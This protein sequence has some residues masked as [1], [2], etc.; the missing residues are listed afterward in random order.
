M[1]ATPFVSVV[2][3][4]IR[5]TLLA[6]VLPVILSQ[7]YPKGE[8]EVIVVED[9]TESKV[10]ELVESLSSSS[11][12]EIS[13]YWKERGGPAAAR[14]FGVSKAKGDFIVFI[15]DDCLPSVDWLKILI[16][17]FSS[18]SQA[19]AVGGYME[20]PE[21]LLVKNIFAQF[22]SYQTHQVYKAGSFPILSGFDSPAGGSNNLAYKKDIF[23]DF[24]GFDESFPLPAGE[25]ADLKKRITDAG[26]KFLYLPVKVTHLQQYNFRRFIY[27]SIA[28]GKGAMLFEK[29][30]GGWRGNWG[31][32]LNFAY[33]WL[34]FIRNLLKI[35]NKKI[36]ILYLI[37]DTLM[38]WGR[39]L[40]R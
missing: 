30:H 2:I 28:R 31:L 18:Y 36:V 39:T 22:E 8:Y 24:G 21:D 10:K 16:Q 27:Q 1:S 17:G 5:E 7:N 29:K 14:N 40:C 9:G 6:K 13:Y 3:P 35:S 23:L 20:A 26:H 15:D 37:Q 4:T 11:D 25:D 33:V 38:W 19:A 12:V 34:S 32:V